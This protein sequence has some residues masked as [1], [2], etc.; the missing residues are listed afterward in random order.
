MTH[1]LNLVLGGDDGCPTQTVFKSTRATLNSAPSASAILSNV[2]RLGKMLPPSSRAN[3]DWVVPTRSASSRWLKPRAS[4]S[5][6]HTSDLQSLI[7][8]S[9]AVFCLKK[10]I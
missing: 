2:G 3:A 6:E 7:S 1:A 5:E 10:K 8:N 9:Y 4:R